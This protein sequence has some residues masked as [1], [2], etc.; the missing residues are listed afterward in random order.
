MN[1]GVT[2]FKKSFLAGP[3]IGRDMMRPRTGE[4][5]PDPPRVSGNGLDFSRIFQEHAPFAWRALRR[6]GV[7]PSDVEDV[8]QEV[9]LVVHRQLAGYE[10]RASLRSWIYGICIR[11]AS[12]HR[13]QSRRRRE[14]VV[15]SPPEM[16]APPEQDETLDRTRA[17]KLL[18]AALDRLDDD[19]RAVF[20]LY[21]IE[22]LTMAEVA[23]A[24]GCPL[25]T[26]YSRLYAAQRQIDAVVRVL[27]IERLRR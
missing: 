12:D 14:D 18:E 13:K 16:E 27:Q 22:D 9:F 1:S 19:K 25:Q 3:F 6:L 8:C 4:V 2:F 26:A 17:V 23:D 7:H 21:E 20:V 10:P 15:D 5:Q 11:T 24:V